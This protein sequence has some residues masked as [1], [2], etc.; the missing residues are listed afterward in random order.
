[1]K[2]SVVLVIF[3]FAIAAFG[4]GCAS[5]GYFASRGRD[6]ADIFTFTIGTGFG[7]KARIGPLQPAI[8]I[9]HD[10]VGLRA[11]EGVVSN[12]DIEHNYEMYFPVPISDRKKSCGFG[13]Y[14][15]GET[16]TK[17]MKDLKEISPMPLIVLPEAPDPGMD[18][19]RTYPQ[20]TQIEVAG[21]A[22]LTVRAGFNIG[23][24]ADFILGWFGVDIYKD[25]F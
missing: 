3:V 23:E 6:A 15:A 14:K 20:F 9:N 22:I 8:L 19:E 5:S 12:L 1:M 11:G 18:E 13:Y 17:R 25:D 7:I 10:M 24:F 4:T 16:A 21:G 2:R